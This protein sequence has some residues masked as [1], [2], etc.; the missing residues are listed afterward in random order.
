MRPGNPDFTSGTGK[1][2]NRL[3]RPAPH[4]RC[5][6]K[7]GIAAVRPAADVSPGFLC[8]FHYSGE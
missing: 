3:R 6:E 5:R 8:L 2:L 4:V 1:P 7:F